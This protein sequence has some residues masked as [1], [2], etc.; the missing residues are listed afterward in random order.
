MVRD[1]A[2]SVVRH[3]RSTGVALKLVQ[4]A[5]Q[6]RQFETLG[7]TANVTR[8]M[9]KG[10]LVFRHKPVECDVETLCASASTTTNRR[11]HQREHVR[12]RSRLRV[13]AIPSIPIS[14]PAASVSRSTCDS[15]MRCDTM[16]C[17]T[18]TSIAPVLIRCRRAS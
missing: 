13:P 5:V 18:L 15:A 14:F 8:S 6:C 11:G 16:A 7:Q 1:I 12:R 17:R 4:Y 9:K 2:T 3:Q 10:M